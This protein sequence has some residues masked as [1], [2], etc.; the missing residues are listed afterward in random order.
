MVKR[1]VLATSFLWSLSLPVHA[2]DFIYFMRPGDNVWAVSQVM[3][4]TPS[5]WPKLAAYNH[6]SDPHKLLPNHRIRIP[7]HWL[8]QTPA[9]ARLISVS[10]NVNIERLGQPPIPGRSGAEIRAHDRIVTTENS[11]AIIGFAD[12]SRLSVA[13]ASALSFNHLT[14]LGDVSMVDTAMHL[15]Y[16]SVESKVQPRLSSS[17][18][19]DIQTPIGITSVRGTQY[20]VSFAEEEKTARAEVIEGRVQVSNPAGQQLVPGGQ[21]SFNREGQ[22]PAAPRPLLQPMKVDGLPK[23]IEYLPPA[24]PLHPAPGAARYEVEVS[25]DPDFEHLLTYRVFDKPRWSAADLPDGEYWMR[26][27]AIDGDGLRGMDAV[28]ALTVAARPEPPLPVLPK[29]NGIV[30]GS[31]VSLRWSESVSAKQY[32]LRVLAENERKELI[33]EGA[34]DATEHRLQNLAE[35]AYRWHIASIDPQGKQG[36][37]GPAQSFRI[38]HAPPPPGAET[39]EADGGNLEVRWR[40]SEGGGVRYAWQLA[41]DPA[42]ADIVRQ[43][44]GPEPSLRMPRPEAGDYFLRIRVIDD[45]AYPPPYG[46]VQKIEVPY[47]WSWMVPLGGMLLLV[48]L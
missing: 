41:R 28:H 25:D 2:E 17:L 35:G 1:L 20:R 3:L 33:F 23:L 36:P 13:P 29:E 10:G 27:R 12:G 14:A 37:F 19:F 21:G 47:D 22:P 6:V 46:P 4:H 15:A 44:E 38:R 43:G 24:M 40:A 34:L 48:L 45:P 16:G 31:D 39:P 7:E 8:K 5:L 26:M 11:K 9:S 42:F 18:R 32:R 30:R